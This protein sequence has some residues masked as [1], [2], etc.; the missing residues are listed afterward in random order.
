MAKQAR[1]TPVSK[2]I[3]IPSLALGSI[4]LPS[5]YHFIVGAG[6]PIF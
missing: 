4:S 3:S 1:P 6:L 5:L 2:V